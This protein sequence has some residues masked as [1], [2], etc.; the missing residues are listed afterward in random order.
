MRPMISNTPY[1]KLTIPELSGG[2]NLRDGIS[3]IGDN[4]LTDCKNVWYKDGMLR[5]RPGARYKD[6]YDIEKDV[7]FG[8]N[9]IKNVYADSKN[10]RVIGGVTYY[11][12]CL[13]TSSRL[14]FRYYRDDD[15]T[16]ENTGMPYLEVGRIG[17]DNLPP[18]D[19]TC[20]IFQHGNDIYCFCSGYYEGESVPYYIYKISEVGTDA[21]KAAWSISRVGVDEGVQPYVPTVLINGAPSESIV[22]SIDK[23]V[24][25]GATLFEGY[26]LIGNQYKMLVSNALK[27]ESASD[28]EVASDQMKYTLLFDTRDFIGHTVTATITDSEGTPHEHSLKI[29]GDVQIETKSDDGLLMRV[30]GFMLQFI[31]ADQ[32]DVIAKTLRSYYMENCIEITAPCPN[33][34]ENYEKVLNMSFNEWYGGGSE[35]LY[36]GIHLFMGGNKGYEKSLVCWSD[37]N[38]PLY[39][40][41][42]NY[43]YVG[44]K[45]QAVTA[46]GKQGESLMIFKESE[47]YATQYST[48]NDSISADDVINQAVVDVAANEVAF[49][50][51][52]VHGF[53][54]CDCP[55]TVQL[56][57]NRLV[58]AHSDGKVYTLVSA[59]QYNERTV[60]EV[61]DM[62]EKRLKTHSMDEL[63]GALSADWE[64]HYI[65]SVGNKLYLM[66]YNSYGYSNIYSYSKSEDA[67]KRIPW[68]LWDLPEYTAWRYVYGEGHVPERVCIGKLPFTVRAFMGI[69]D[70]LLISGTLISATEEDYEMHLHVMEYL[71]FGN[72]KDEFPKFWA[73]D[74]NVIGPIFEYDKAEPLEIPSMLQTKFFDFGS[75]TVKKN[76]PKVEVAFGTNGGVPIKTTV[77]TENAADEGEFVIDE[78]EEQEYS[79]GYFQNRLIRPANKRACRIGLRF[80]SEGDMSID[81]ISLQYKSLGGLK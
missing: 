68:W 16:E 10:Y 7:F 42:N 80:E 17:S 19:F 26:N 37:F 39:F 72:M 77:I 5:T 12:V 11:L 58:W 70:R 25:R 33:A 22:E 52:Q 47:I 38:K 8:G 48:L 34:R 3:L 46:F 29:S 36:G 35:G 1:Y 50:M 27:Y 6:N 41:E 28:G 40:S 51:V 24:S 43:A 78:P 66:D 65:L 13:Q 49:P 53:I 23:M 63:Q 15:E 9:P 4:Q 21:A 76:V 56:C 30:A 71:K 55:H 59:N 74:S 73:Y 69:A 18:S 20:N 79:P 75:P 44:D 2:V 61:S 54:G 60:F 67:Q 57:R 32:S 14:E 62:V 45:S 31:E 81:A 64:G